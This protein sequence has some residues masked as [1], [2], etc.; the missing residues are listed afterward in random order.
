[1]QKMITATDYPCISA[2]Q[3]DAACMNAAQL[4]KVRAGY[5]L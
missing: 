5:V 3:I 2:S 1:M 4:A